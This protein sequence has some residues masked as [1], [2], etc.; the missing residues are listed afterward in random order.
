[1]TKGNNLET[2]SKKI[3]IPLSVGRKATKPGVYIS[4]I[5][6]VEQIWES[7]LKIRVDYELTA[8]TGQK[9][10]FSEQFVCSERNSRWQTFAEYVST[11]MHLGS[12]ADLADIVGLTEVVELNQNGTFLNIGQRCLKPKDMKAADLATFSFDS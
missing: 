5:V 12:D 10:Q 7:P 2:T 4:R 9:C 8:A 11:G 6:N 3:G 1:M